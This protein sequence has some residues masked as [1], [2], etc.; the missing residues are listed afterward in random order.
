MRPFHGGRRWIGNLTL[1]RQVALL[2][3]IPIVV[4]GLMLARVLQGGR[5]SRGHSQRCLISR[6]S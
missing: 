1:T 5:S 3:L 6:R 4:L 2:S